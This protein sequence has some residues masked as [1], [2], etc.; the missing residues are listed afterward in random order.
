MS[1]GSAKHMTSLTE[2]L[3]SAGVRDVDTQTRRRA[4]YSA[5]A[6]LY[7]V[8][9]QAVVFPRNAE[10]IV[11]AIAVARERGVPITPR[12]A[13]TSIAGN[14]IGPGMV[15]DVRRHMGRVIEIDPHAR[16][17]RVGPGVVLDDLQAAASSY[18]LRFGPDPSTHDRCTLG[19]MIGNNACGTRS[20]AYGTTADNVYDSEIVDGTGWHGLLSEHPTPGLSALIDSYGDAIATHLGQFSRQLSGYGL[21][22]L[23]TSSNA[24]A[25]PIVQAFVGSEGTCGVVTE[26]TVRLVEVPAATLLVVLG[27]PD[28]ASAADA[29]PST[30]AH[31]PTAV[32]GLDGRIVR[33]ARAHGRPIPQLP[34]GD[35]FLFVE[36]A[37][38][39]HPEL[40]ERARRVIADATASDARVVSDS[41]EAAALWKMREAG[42]GLAARGGPRPAHPGWEDAAV[43]V[44]SLG[45]Y[46]RSFE[47]L[48]DE[49]ALEGAPYGHFG[50]G[51]VH[52]RLDL[53]FDRA[54][55]AHVFRNFLRDATHLV[56]QFGGST[57]GEH[58]DGRA[59][60]ELLALRYP[61]EILAAFAA[62]A[63]IF[64][65]DDCLNPGIIVNPQP[66]DANLRPYPSVAVDEPTTTSLLHG[67]ESIA[68]AVHRCIGVG[69]CVSSGTGRT[70][71][72]MCPSYAAT[73]D[74]RDS[75]R[76]RAR[77][78]QE[79]I[80]GGFGSAANA[81]RAPEVRE[82]LS[83]C[84]G[85]KACATDCPTGV[86]MATYRTE[87]LAATYRRRLRPRV[88]Y[89]LGHLP[90]V[91]RL[92]APIAPAINALLGVPAIAALSKWLAGVDANRS[93]PTLATD[94]LVRPMKQNAVGTGSQPPVRDAVLWVDTL[95]EYVTPDIARAAYRVLEEA[96]YR[97]HVP[98]AGYCCG[99]P[100]LST[101]QL[102]AAQR[103]ARKLIAV[104]DE[105]PSGTPIVGLEPSCIA[106]LRFDVPRL[107]PSPATDRVAARVQTLA[108]ALAAQ[109][110]AWS[111]PDLQDRTIV[112]QVHCHQY[113]QMG[114]AAERSLLAAAG[115][116]VIDATGCCGLAGDFGM[117]R[118]RFGIS[119]AIAETGLTAVLQAH[120]AAQVLADGASCRMQINDLTDRHPVHLAELLA[121]SSLHDANED[122]P[123]TK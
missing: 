44:A 103:S 80:S 73:Q 74:E 108:E 72:V 77:V 10:E 123:P 87:V 110:P 82:A 15:L 2:A 46:L 84:L 41:D 75:T 26:A 67:S 48:L 36:V 102:N 105:T 88:H 122:G 23:F 11:A 76:G 115:A 97:V 5:D 91:L 116:T 32:E 85:C 18:G 31:T 53:P 81:L 109:R 28:M 94:R 66:V 96:G 86:D 68:T 40:H 38:A 51:C 37:G 92:A 71:R 100:M 3:R 30:L 47:A 12:G 43:P 13:G 6:S 62:F 104:L 98:S 24:G 93:I 69:A 101:G 118:G 113:A 35:G 49:Y 52:V 34:R 59:R 56:A 70:S 8:V 50:D 95:S 99:L 4:E 16:L 1:A 29:A 55:G 27:Y 42:A 65:P 22:A 14:A 60:S 111:P 90:R 57:T 112:A 120:P 7:R 19:G 78:L 89:S 64:D 117:A 17:A 54:D 25:A 58:G 79:A 9:P 107:A 39:N 114:F 121:T 63:A 20:V 119:K 21:A 45:S 106:A 83:L 33:I 61:P